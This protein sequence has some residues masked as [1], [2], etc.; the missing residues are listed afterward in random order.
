[1]GLFVAAISSL[2]A[3]LK[4]GMVWF[5]AGGGNS[6]EMV[7]S[8]S[9]FGNT[10]LRGWLFGPREMPLLSCPQILLSFSTLVTRSDGSVGE[11]PAKQIL[12]P[13]VSAIRAELRGK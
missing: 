13:S 8:E 4:R 6:Y 7:S 1:M 10:L 9:S 12:V 5:P 11:K 3:T 2:H